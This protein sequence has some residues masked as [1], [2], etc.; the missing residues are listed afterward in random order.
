MAL[1]NLDTSL[2]SNFITKLEETDMSYMRDDEEEMMQE[3]A[4][5]ED[6]EEMEMDMDM[7]VDAEP[8]MGDEEMDME[9]DMEVEAEPEEEAVLTDDEADAIIALADKLRAARDG[10]G[11]DDL[12][13]EEEIEFD[14]EEEMP[15]EEETLEEI[16]NDVLGEEMSE[17]EEEEWFAGKSA[18]DIEL[19]QLQK[20]AAKEPEHDRDKSAGKKAIDRV[21]SRKRETPRLNEEDLVQEVLRR[22]K[23]RLKEMKNRKE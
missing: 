12:G 21:R 16:L 10:D 15:E 7:E 3:E 8:E 18:A 6:E 5:E 19:A 14:A 9:M 4:D 2:S 20:R 23:T 13:S 11:V 17:D 22:V 1:A